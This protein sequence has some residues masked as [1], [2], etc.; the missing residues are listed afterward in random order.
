MI[1]PSR[2]FWDPLADWREAPPGP[3]P[4]PSCSSR[5]LHSWSLFL[6]LVLGLLV[7]YRRGVYQSVRGGNR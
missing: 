3:L 1:L 2:S 7:G 4:A 5:K 6:A